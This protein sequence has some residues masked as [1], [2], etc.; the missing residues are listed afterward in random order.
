[1]YQNFIISYFKW[2]ST[3]FGRYTAHHQESK[4]AQAASLFAYVEGCPTTARP[5][6]FHYAK[7]EAACAVLGS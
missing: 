4:T 7:P 1:V 3:C 2:S 6:T 5:T